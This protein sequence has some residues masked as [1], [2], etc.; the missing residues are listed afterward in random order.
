M[1]RVEHSIETSATPERVWKLF[2]DVSAWPRWDSGVDSVELHGTFS[3]GTRFSMHLSAGESYTG[4]LVD[5]CRNESFADETMIEG[6]RVLVRHKV[7]P[8]PSGNSR[9]TFMAEVSGPNA[10]DLGEWIA[11][12]FPGVLEDLRRLAECPE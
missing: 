2:S 10:E 7:E 9:I 4:T 11:E 8:L 6:A 5:V 3:M 12:D 1:W